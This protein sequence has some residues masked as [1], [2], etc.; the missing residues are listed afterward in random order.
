M[1]I[2]SDLLIQTD[3]LLFKNTEIL[4]ILMAKS[5][6]I[7]IFDIQKPCSEAFLKRV[8]RLADQTN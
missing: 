8:V 2:A 5:N 3:N 4:G 1:P 6:M 7:E